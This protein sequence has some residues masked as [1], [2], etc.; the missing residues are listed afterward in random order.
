MIGILRDRAQS[1][2]KSGR[3]KLETPDRP[4]R[5]IASPGNRSSSAKQLPFR[6][7]LSRRAGCGQRNVRCLR[8]TELPVQASCRRR[9]GCD[10]SMQSQSAGQGCLTKKGAKRNTGD[11]RCQ[12][13]RA[14]LSRRCRH[15]S[16]GQPRQ[17][18]KNVATHARNLRAQ[19]A[20]RHCSEGQ[21]SCQLAKPTASSHRFPPAHAAAALCHRSAVRRAWLGRTEK[22]PSFRQCRRRLRQ[23]SHRSTRRPARQRPTFRTKAECARATHGPKALSA[24]IEGWFATGQR[25]QEAPAPCSICIR[26]R[27]KNSKPRRA[28]AT[29]T[30]LQPH[31][32]TGELLRQSTKASPKRREK[33][34]AASQA[35]REPEHRL[36]PDLFGKHRR[37]RE[38]PRSVALPRALPCQPGKRPLQWPQ[39]RRHQSAIVI[40]A[41]RIW[42]C[43]ALCVPLPTN[44]PRRILPPQLST[45]M[46]SR[47]V[48]LKVT[49]HREMSLPLLLR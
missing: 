15:C 1:A 21:R 28:R 46:P 12:K 9:S 10:G 23:H 11:S 4:H 35:L 42:R 2:P 5:W 17:C 37:K 45:A 13:T 31:A 39:R 47:F 34:A 29:G 6:A 49:F 36:L 33:P 48:K 22:P 7:E 14:P 30:H 27:W 16:P 32:A 38:P 18:G 43:R 20:E 40:L 24:R 44:V 8:L 41:G 26:R 3:R 19:V 25:S